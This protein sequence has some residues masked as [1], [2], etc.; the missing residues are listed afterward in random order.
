MANDP[1]Q[2]EPRAKR[3]WGV[4][5][6]WIGGI[7]AVI[8]FIGTLS[9]TFG[10]IQD[11][12][13]GHAELDQKM[14]IAQNQSQQ[15]DYQAAVQGYAEIL[16]GNSL[17]AP[18]LD[19]QLQTTML[20][21]ENY[22]VFVKE[23]QDSG[24]VA[25]PQLD[26][27]VAILDAG[28]ARTKGTQAA[29]VEAHLGWAHWLNQHIAARE[30]G[31]TAEHDLRA[32]LAL[33]PSNV[34]ANAML[35]NWMLQNGGD[36]Q[37]AVGHFQTAVATGKAR[38]LVRTMQIGGLI[39]NESHSSCVELIRAANDMRKDG[40]PLNERDKSR[41]L[42][43]CFGPSMDDRQRIVESLSAVP[44]DDAFQTY[45]W[46]DDQSRQGDDATYHQL[47]HDFVQANVLEISGRRGEALA[48]YRALQPELK[49]R[50][51][52]MQNQVDEAV[53]RLS[54]PQ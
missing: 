5:L 40:E 18:A 25:A 41:I 43:E 9:G 7:S 1:Q 36:F 37:E 28:L 44:P 53:T 32:A 13:H 11:H 14:A 10:K 46:L 47:I 29:D 15:G 30:F 20:W 26:Q 50:H 19:R 31:P 2:P 51:S 16:K 42:F 6:A 54:R 49:N 22:S 17:Y 35:G 12:F 8:G 39:S 52:T 4:I 3:A 38:A 23:D 21:V 24:P 45:L 34:Y 48:K 33:D 27:I